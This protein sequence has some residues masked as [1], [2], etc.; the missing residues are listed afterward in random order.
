M[1]R[2]P[3]FMSLLQTVLLF[4]ACSRTGAQSWTTHDDPVGFSI[5]TPA[6]WAVMN[7]EGRITVEGP[8][9]ER[10]T[11]YPLRIEGELDAKRAQH[12]MV[13][14]S[15]QLWPRQRWRMPKGG[16][17][18]GENG[19]RAIGEDESERRESVA[20]WWANTPQGAAGFLYAVAA[21]P[22]HFKAMEPVF[23]RILGSF[24]VTNANA[25]GVGR[26]QGG[27]G[28]DPLAGL[29]F[30]RWNDPTENAF[31]AEVPAGWRVSGGIRRNSPTSR[32]DEIVAQSPDGQLVRTNDASL[33][34]Q[35]MEPN[36]TLER[37]G[38][39]EGMMYPGT[40]NPVMRFRPAVNFATEYV[41]MKTSQTCRN[42]Q[43]VNQ[44]DRPDILQA[45]AA[46]GLLSNNQIT[47]GEVVFTCLAGGQPYVGYLFAE[48][49]R[50][51]YQGVGNI[52]NARVNGFFAPAARAAQADAVLQ[53]IQA[54]LRINPQWW[55]AEVGA[56]ARILKNFEDYRA[57]SAQLQQQTANE[58]LASLDRRTD[59]A[60]DIMQGRTRVVDTESGESYKVQHTSNYYWIDTRNEVIAGTNIPYKP[61]WDFREMIQTYR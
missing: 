33:P 61:S 28:S 38:I 32:T 23:A 50:S 9:A 54:S 31:S 26:R 21:A 11:I 20:L 59:Q 5:E 3:V 25:R 44:R 24:R 8:N 30:Q 2:L 16:W 18:F 37:L 7:A 40:N 35:F 22:P 48:T 4:A 43:F 53:R 17:Q 29:Q 60:N 15:N 12:L 51:V 52:W 13:G 34:T 19:V 39:R 14:L 6:A 10:V 57:F 47:A 27:Q 41:Q 55:A 45:L 36:Q 58:R 46:R 42:L 1:F 49:S 56:D